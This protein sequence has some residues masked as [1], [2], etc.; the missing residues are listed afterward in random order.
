[1]GF[2]AG[3]GELHSNWIKNYLFLCRDKRASLGK[4]VAGLVN[5]CCSG[6]SKDEAVNVATAFE[7]C[8]QSAEIFLGYGE[9]NINGPDLFELLKRFT[10]TAG[11]TFYCF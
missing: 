10:G 8:K 7:E 6:L 4:L 3:R 9:H 2:Q 5:C 1:L 11:S